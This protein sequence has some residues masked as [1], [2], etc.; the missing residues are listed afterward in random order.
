MAAAISF[1][2][3]TFSPE[4]DLIRGLLF[5]H[6]IAGA[7]FEFFTIADGL[8]RRNIIDSG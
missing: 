1:G 5:F 6:L 2:K 7:A 8:A 4:C 3:A